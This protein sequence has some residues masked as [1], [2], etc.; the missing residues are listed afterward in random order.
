VNPPRGTAAALLLALCH[1]IGWAAGAPEPLGAAGAL[2]EAAPPPGQYDASLCVTVGDQAAQCGPVVVDIGDNGLALVSVADLRYRL[3]PMR[4]RLGVSLFQGNM[5]LDG[6]FASHQWSGP[7]LK[8]SDPDKPTR[9][10]LQLGK[11]RM[12]PQ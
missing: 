7:V 9:Y 1:A 12:A 2:T 4:G 6:F 3:E 8:F 5:Q 11:R 10:E